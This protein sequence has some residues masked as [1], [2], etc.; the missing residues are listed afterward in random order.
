M[1]RGIGIIIHGLVAGH[2]FFVQTQQ[3]DDSVFKLSRYHKICAGIFFCMLRHQGSIDSAEYDSDAGEMIS[4]LAYCLLQS[5][6]PVGHPGC[7]EDHI[8]TESPRKLL[9]ESFDRDAVSTE[10]AP[11]TVERIRCRNGPLHEF[12]PAILFL[13]M[14]V[15]ETI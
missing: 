5:A 15:V 3:R 6:I 14:P 9:P 1:P 8:G 13:G 7:Y 2:G 11:N 4:Q 10:S 12:S